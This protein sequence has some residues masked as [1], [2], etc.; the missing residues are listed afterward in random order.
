[1][2]EVKDIKIEEAQEEKKS[3]LDIIYPNLLSVKIGKINCKVQKLKFKQTIM[4]LQI[5]FA[6]FPVVDWS[7]FIKDPQQLTTILMIAITKAT[8]A[9]YGFL[10]EMLICDK[11]QR[12]DLQKYIREE[13]ENN[14]MLDVIEAIMSQEQDNFVGWL[15]KVT[16]MLQVKEIQKIVLKK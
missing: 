12:E 14:E 13:F 16:G 4:L 5:I 11:P 3:D 9:F 10:D 2:E 1:M 15:K 8:G 6:T 7:V